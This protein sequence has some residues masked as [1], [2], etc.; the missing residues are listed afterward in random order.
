M[1]PLSYSVHRIPSWGD[2][3]LRLVTTDRGLA[4]VE[5]F[6]ESPVKDERAHAR[7]AFLSLI[8]RGGA[9]SAIL[10]RAERELAEY[11]AGERRRFE[12]PLDLEV[13]RALAGEKKARRGGGFDLAIWRAL[14]DI[15]FGT[16]TSYGELAHV[17]GFGAQA[18]RAVGQA[19][20]RNPVAIVVPCHRVVGRDR[21]LTGFSC[22]LDFKERLL[23]L[24]GFRLEEPRR[25]TADPEP[26]A[27]RRVVLRTA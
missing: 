21:S 6:R 9:P 26:R 18:S 24:E 2:A 14:Q 27:R 7:S 16:L 3:C 10:A 13:G 8:E 5:L 20:G 11:F 17:A 23:A 12:V 25:R 4:S 19:V 1:P 15:P 22:G